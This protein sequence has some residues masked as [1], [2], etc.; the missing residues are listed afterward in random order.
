M[1]GQQIFESILPNVKVSCISQTN[2]TAKWIALSHNFAGWF[3]FRTILEFYRSMETISKQFMVRF[4]GWLPHCSC[5]RSQSVSFQCLEDNCPHQHRLTNNSI[6]DFCHLKGLF[7]AIH[8]VI[9]MIATSVSMLKCYFVG[10]FWLQ[11]LK[12]WNI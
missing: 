7:L 1:N 3:A 4:F 9:C 5:I 11:E 8:N 12:F 10:I 2:Q 6:S